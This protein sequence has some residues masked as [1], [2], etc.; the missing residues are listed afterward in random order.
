[1]CWSAIRVSPPATHPDFERFLT[2]YMKKD[3]QKPD[4]QQHKAITAQPMLSL[5]LSVCFK[6]TEIYC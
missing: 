4:L 6:T 1:M 5:F 3:Q 2:L